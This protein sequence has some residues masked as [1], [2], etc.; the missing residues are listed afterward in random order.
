YILIGVTEEPSSKT[1]VLSG[2]QPAPWITNANLQQ[3]VRPHL[4][5]LP[6]FSW[7]LLEVDGMSVGVIEIR[8][9]GR[10]FFALHDKHNL[11]RHIALVRPGS[12]TDI[13]SPDEI[14]QWYVEDE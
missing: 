3:K 4:N 5:R 1:G 7:A 12:T 2:F 8:H 9:G 10:P 11:R 13:A 14:V 6:K